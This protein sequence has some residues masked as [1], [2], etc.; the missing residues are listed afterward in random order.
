MRLKGYRLKSILQHLT[1]LWYS[2]Y[3]IAIAAIIATTLAFGQ[4]K[5]GLEFWKAKYYSDM[6]TAIITFLSIIIGIFGILMPSVITAKEDRKGMVNYFFENADGEFFAKCIKRIISSG[7]LSVIFICLLYL[8]DIIDGK[9]YIW[10]FRVS[11]FLILYFCFGSYR[12]IGIML[13]LLIGGKNKE[14]IEKGVKKYKHKIDESERKRIN[15]Q[16]MNK[17]NNIDINKINRSE[18]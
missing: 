2:W 5:Y 11:I 15:E 14:D 1:D 4:Y 17:N 10:I 9:I 18:E 13:R 6:L 8:Q 7:I 3:S 16:L 12:F